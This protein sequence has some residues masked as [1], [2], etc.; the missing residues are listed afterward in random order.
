MVL[1]S[2]FKKQ[3]FKV[4]ETHFLY[5]TALSSPNGLPIVVNQ[6]WQYIV[7]FSIAVLKN[8]NGITLQQP[9]KHMYL[10]TVTSHS[11]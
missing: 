5:K 9:H 2:V 6:I 4:N 3:L 10:H 8:V 1:Y 11:C 7:I